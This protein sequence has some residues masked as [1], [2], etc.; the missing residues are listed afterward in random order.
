MKW[1]RTLVSAFFILLSCHGIRS[2]AFFFPDFNYPFTATSAESFSD[3]NPATFTEPYL[4]RFVVSH[5]ALNQSATVKLSP[6][7]SFLRRDYD[8][9]PEEYQIKTQDTRYFPLLVACGGEWYGYHWGVDFK[10][11]GVNVFQATAHYYFTNPVVQTMDDIYL[12]I[13]NN[14][15]FYRLRGS[16]SVAATKHLAVAVAPIL[17]FGSYSLTTVKDYHA[18]GEHNYF[19]DYSVRLHSAMTGTGL[20]LQLGFLFRPEYNYELSALLEYN[21]RLTFRGK[22][23]LD[24]EVSHQDL[25]HRLPLKAEFVWRYEPL[26]SL[27]IESLIRVEYWDGNLYTR[28]PEAFSLTTPKFTTVTVWGLGVSYRCAP[29]WVWGAGYRFMDLP[30]DSETWKF[31]ELD[32]RNHLVSTSL[33]RSLRDVEVSLAASAII[34]EGRLLELNGLTVAGSMLYWF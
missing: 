10:L 16:L 12:K 18:N 21:D 17:Y 19:E 2:Q 23:K 24:T 30:R 3:D 28:Q 31:F 13:K 14:L 34:E 20:G 29:S 6:T 15:Q 25:V 26:D 8:F 4:I 11:A 27:T 5:I 32:C 22:T 7:S 9:E 1:S 33:S